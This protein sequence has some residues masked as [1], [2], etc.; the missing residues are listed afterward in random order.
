VTF[1]GIGITYYSAGS[2]Q[3]ALFGNGYGYLQPPIV[4]KLFS[5]FHAEGEKTP[6]VGQQV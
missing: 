2:S 6:V 1:L 3:R 5:D 4:R